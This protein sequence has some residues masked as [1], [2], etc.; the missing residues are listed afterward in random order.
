[1]QFDAAILGAVIALMIF[2]LTT[3]APRLAH[4]YRRGVLEYGELAADVG[5]EFEGRWLATR[6]VK[7]PGA[8]LD[9]S[10]FSATIDLY[11]VVANVHAMRLVPMALKDVAILLLFSL[12]PFVPILLATV[13]ADV[14]W[15]RLKDLLL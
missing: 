1:V 15:A 12:L 8:G 9:E 2:P 6:A 4:T 7:A 13:P 14:L 10:D 5:R 11:S 3:L